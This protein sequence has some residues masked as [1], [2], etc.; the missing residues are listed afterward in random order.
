MG[1][2]REEKVGRALMMVLNV[3][4]QQGRMTSAQIPT[5][6]ILVLWRRL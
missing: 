1:F 2:I 4:L 6:K 3:K 5:R